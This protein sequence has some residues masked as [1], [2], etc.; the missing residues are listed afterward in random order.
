MELAHAPIVS[1]EGDSSWQI[2]SGDADGSLY[3]EA[4]LTLPVPLSVSAALPVLDESSMC[5]P[6]SASFW[7]IE[8]IESVIES[9]D[10][11][12]GELFEQGPMGACDI[13]DLE[14]LLEAWLLSR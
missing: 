10:G 6:G 9:S 1:D 2:D 13:G 12:R 3:Q 8:R 5:N 7:G 14:G 11:V 4:L